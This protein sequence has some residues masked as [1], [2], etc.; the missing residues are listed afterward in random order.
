MEVRSRP[1]GYLSRLF[2]AIGLCLLILKGSYGQ[3]IGA[4]CRTF[5]RGSL[6]APLQVKAYLASNSAVSVRACQRFGMESATYSARYPVKKSG[7]ICNFDVNPL[8]ETVTPSGPVLRDETS[9]GAN[10]EMATA[11]GSCSTLPDD[12]YVQT[13][14]LSPA[15]FSRLTILWN[16]AIVSVRDFDSNSWDS[17]SDSKEGQGLRKLVQS[18]RQNELK[19]RSISPVFSFGIWNLYELTIAL[20]SARTE[21]LAVYVTTWFGLSMRISHVGRVEI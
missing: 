16:K 19:L 3:I 8:S 21:M 1:L 17:V 13:F 12:Q 7:K 14:D 10:V 15:E 20:P 11:E 9:L 6:D 2:L 5:D 4:N 18:G